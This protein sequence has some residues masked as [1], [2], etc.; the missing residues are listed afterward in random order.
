MRSITERARALE[1]E[2]VFLGGP[3]RF[4]GTAGRKTLDALRA[5]GL[6]PSSKVLDVGCGCLRIGHR[7]IEHLEPGGYCGIEPDARMLEAGIR[8]LL[9]ED[10]V[11][12]R[13]PRFDH[14]PDFDFTVFGERFDFLLAR[15]I[16]THAS[17]DQIR[18]MLDGFVTVAAPGALFLTS[19]VRASWFRRDYRGDGWVG[20]S[21]ES[22]RAGMVA[23]DLEWIR[24]ECARRDLGVEPLRG[25]KY[26]FGRQAWL[27]IRRGEA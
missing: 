11:E 17:K 5:E 2:G 19:Y 9:D 16:W 6:T 25:R 13:A 3:V 21:H 4:F 24:E 12:T 15:S 23:H 20:R 22:T 1:G 18:K 10:V 14:D 27:R 8:H 26:N 7:L